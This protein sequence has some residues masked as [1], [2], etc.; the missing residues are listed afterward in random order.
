[1][2]ILNLIENTEGAAGCLCEHGLS[3]YIE[4]GE[5]KILVDTGASG[6]FLMNAEWMRKHLH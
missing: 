4:T 2:R 5:H 6:A 1:M 3:F